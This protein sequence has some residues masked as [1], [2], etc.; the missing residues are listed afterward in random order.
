MRLTELEP[1]LYTWGDKFILILKCPCC[2][3]VWLTCG[4]PLSV[5]NQMRFWQKSGYTGTIVPYNENGWTLQG[6]DLNTLTVNPS[7][8]AY[9]THRDSTQAAHFNITNGM[10]H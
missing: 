2:R 7:L 3:R 4:S 10:I 6:K 5:G 9:E 1:R 8:N